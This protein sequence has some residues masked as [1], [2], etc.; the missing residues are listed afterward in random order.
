[1]KR[2]MMGIILG[3]EKYDKS[4]LSAD[5]VLINE[6]IE[7]PEHLVFRLEDVMRIE[8]RN[9]IRNALLRAQIYLTLNLSYDME[10]NQKRLYTA[11]SIE[12][13]L[14]GKTFWK[15]ESEKVRETRSAKP[16]RPCV[17]YPV[18]QERDLRDSSPPCA[19]VLPSVTHPRSD[20]PVFHP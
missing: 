1:M 2:D 16:Y 10:A 6:V 5:Y 15:K 14:F 12:K 7:E 9:E 19:S 3:K 18:L 11:K 8:P 20:P 4:D 17:S 13:L